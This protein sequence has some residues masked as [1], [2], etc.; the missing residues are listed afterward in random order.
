MQTRSS[1]SASASLIPFD[2][3]PAGHGRLSRETQLQI[4]DPTLSRRKLF[5]GWTVV[6]RP[7]SSSPRSSNGSVDTYYIEA[8]TGR[9]FPSLESVQRHLAGLVDERRLTRTGSFLNENS[10]IYEGSRTKQNHRSVEYASKG[11]RL[12]RGWTVEEVPRKNAY[13]IDKYYTERKTGKRFRSLVSVE[14]YL[15]ESRNC[16][17][18]QLMV[19]QSHRGLSKGF[20]LPEGWIV[21]EK[22]RRYSSHIDRSYIEPVT[23]KKFRSL[24]AV[25]RYLR[26]VGSGRVDSASMVG[27]LL[28]SEMLL[29]LA[30]RNGTGFQTEVLDPNPPGRVKWIFT[31]PGG[32]KFSAHVN[33]SD[34]SGSVKQTWSEAFVSLI[35][36]RS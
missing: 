31:G 24:P 8:G 29:L 1:S 13:H 5:P 14:R 10:R 32:N 6:N 23:G 25:E 15:Q 26:A 22:P 4:V 33:G 17:D 11:F 7:G 3:F 28:H 9:E 35:H 20:S 30:N 18:Q 34:V 16:T 27:S 19:L 2:T 21:E 36:D 12:P